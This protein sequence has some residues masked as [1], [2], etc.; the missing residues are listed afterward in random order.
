MFE[1][2]KKYRNSPKRTVI[3]F[4]LVKKMS[5]NKLGDL[6]LAR[7][8]KNRVNG[9]KINNC[10][11][12][13]SCEPGETN[14]NK[15]LFIGQD[16]YSLENCSCECENDDGYKNE[17][18]RGEMTERLENDSAQYAFNTTSNIRCC[19]G[20]NE[21]Q[22]SDSCC[23]SDRFILPCMKSDKK[24]GFVFEKTIRILL[25]DLLVGVGAAAIICKMMLK[26][27]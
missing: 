8:A 17:T 11:N 25:C 6:N 14:E 22:N 12:N 20:E 21:T 19:D 27:E 13:S 23:E 15:T 18:D 24:G 4:E 9:A 1:L 16:N 7:K 26:R 3:S 5:F 10:S 2:I